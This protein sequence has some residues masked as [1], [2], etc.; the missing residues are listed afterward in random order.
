MLSKQIHCFRCQ[1]E[2]KNIYIYISTLCVSSHQVA[3]A[4]ADAA[5]AGASS[6]VAPEGY[7]FDAASGYWH[8]AEAGMYYDTTSGSYFDGA[9]WLRYVESSG[10]YEPL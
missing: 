10:T 1:S 4:A 6:A 9:R 2:I 7:V 5:A 3:E 8:S